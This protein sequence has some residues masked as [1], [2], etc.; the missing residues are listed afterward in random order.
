MFP[1]QHISIITAR[2]SRRVHWLCQLP[3]SKLIRFAYGRLVVS[4]TCVSGVETDWRL[5]GSISCVARPKSFKYAANGSSSGVF[6]FMFSSNSVPTVHRDSM[7]YSARVFGIKMC[8]AMFPVAKNNDKLE[9]S[10][11]LTFRRYLVSV[12]T[13][14]AYF[15]TAANVPKSIASQSVVDSPS[16]LTERWSPLAAFC[17]Y[18][19]KE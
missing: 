3:L 11:T 17:L 10:K 19:G 14:F 9:S 15:W 13:L 16:I 4:G 8:K 7:S 12:E 6:S 5:S 2:I 1:T 18:C